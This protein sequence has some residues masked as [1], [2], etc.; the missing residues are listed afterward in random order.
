MLKSL[1]YGDFSLGKGDKYRSICIL[2]QADIQFDQ[3][4]L[5][6]MLFYFL[7]SNF[8]YFVK[9]NCVDLFL[10]LQFNSIDQSVCFY[11]NA[12]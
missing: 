1:I 2:L 10:G 9:N 6:K 7:P 8:G 3:H 12:M 5:L 11:V 4:Y